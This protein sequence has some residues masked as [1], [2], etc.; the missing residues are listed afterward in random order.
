[1]SSLVKTDI[2][3]L[4]LRMA[5][6]RRDSQNHTW[7][8]TPKP[9]SCSAHSRSLARSPLSKTMFVYPRMCLST[10]SSTPYTMSSTPFFVYG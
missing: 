5:H 4:P 8:T 7:M 6:A 3:R 9:H 10:P 1:M 2:T